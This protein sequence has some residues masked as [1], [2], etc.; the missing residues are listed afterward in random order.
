MC[1]QYF[2][3]GCL[4]KHIF[5]SNLVK[6]QRNLHLSYILVFQ[7]THSLF[8]LLFRMSELAERPKFD[9]LQEALF[10]YLASSTTLEL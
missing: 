3:Q 10:S 6:T 2:I 1:L 4:K 8:K 5:I 9:I 7:K